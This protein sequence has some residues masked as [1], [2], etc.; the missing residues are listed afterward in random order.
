MIDS[1]DPWQEYRKRRNLVLFA[2]LGYMP[3]VFLIGVVAIRLFH[4][5]TPFYVTAF[6]W[7]AFY[8]VAGFRFQTFKCP[9]CRKWFFIRWWPPP[10]LFVQR[11]VHCGLH[12][13]A[14]V[15]G[16]NLDMERLPNNG[17][18]A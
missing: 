9:R 3:V 12:K 1:I 5:T 7:M 4:T 15:S 14:S 18:R 6:G 13:Y 11:C 16:Q 8:A 2:F 10:N 17:G